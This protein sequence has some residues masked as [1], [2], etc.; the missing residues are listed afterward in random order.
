MAQNF[1]GIAVD[2]GIS[3]KQIYYWFLIR[4]LIGDFLVPLITAHPKHLPA[5]IFERTR[6][7]I[8]RHLSILQFRPFQ[9]TSR[10]SSRVTRA[11]PEKSTT[12]PPKCSPNKPA[13]HFRHLHSDLNRV[14]TFESKPSKA[15]WARRRKVRTVRL[16]AGVRSTAFGRRRKAF[17]D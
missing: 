16:V 3:I 9:S 14:E 2:S 13:K 10:G 12:N 5:A 8:H 17:A 11:Q 4:S 15:L 6:I 7:L 1:W